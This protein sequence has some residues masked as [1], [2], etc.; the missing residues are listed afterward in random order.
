MKMT[1]SKQKMKKTIRKD[2]IKLVKAILKAELNPK[3]KI[4]CVI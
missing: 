1:K 4:I 3:D 2:F